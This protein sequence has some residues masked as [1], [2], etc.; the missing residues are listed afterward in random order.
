MTRHIIHGLWEPLIQ[1]SQNDPLHRRR[2]IFVVRRRRE[3]RIDVRS[4]GGS[5]H[6]DDKDS[7]C[8][9]VV[10]GTCAET[11]TSDDCFDVGNG[12]VIGARLH[13][14]TSSESSLMEDDPVRPAT[15]SAAA[16]SDRCWRRCDDDAKRRPLPARCR[17]PQLWTVLSRAFDCA[18][19]L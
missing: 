11:R 2:V 7:S 16:Q 14:G 18:T 4:Q 12:A 9:C 13:L 17:T 5:R 1:K 3:C 19:Y 10:L 15:P 8:S 6:A